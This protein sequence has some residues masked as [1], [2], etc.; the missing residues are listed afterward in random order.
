MSLSKAGTLEI[1]SGDTG[2]LL[3]STTVATPVAEDLHEHVD[4]AILPD[5]DVI[6][7]SAFVSLPHMGYV[8]EVDLETG[9]LLAEIYVGGEPTRL[10]ALDLATGS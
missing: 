7:T 3:R 10:I 9:A 1:R 2:V 4:K 8:V 6:G 5:I